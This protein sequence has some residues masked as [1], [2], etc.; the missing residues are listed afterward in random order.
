[1]LF[2]YPQATMEE[3]DVFL[4]VEWG[5]SVYDWFMD[6]CRKYWQYS[7]RKYSHLFFEKRFK[8]K[9][10][11]VLL[12]QIETIKSNLLTT[13]FLRHKSIYEGV[14][15]V[16][17]GSE[18]NKRNTLDESHMMD[19]CKEFNIWGPKELMENYTYEQYEY[20]YDRIIFKSLESDKKSQIVNDRMR[21]Q[22]W[23]STQDQELSN[24]IAEQKEKGLMDDRPEAKFTIEI[25]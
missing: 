5:K 12:Q 11:D 1:M 22:Q 14:S 15:F 13:M 4:E 18:K 25:W 16:Y 19:V 6:F 8:N 2:R 10:I 21:Q 20:M 7:W 9:T 3:H 23:W 17:S 24:T